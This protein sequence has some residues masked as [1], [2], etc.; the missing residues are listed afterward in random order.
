[1]WICSSARWILTRLEINVSLLHV[2]EPK[3]SILAIVIRSA[4]YSKKAEST[5]VKKNIRVN[6]THSTLEPVKANRVSNDVNNDLSLTNVNG[7]IE[8]WKRRL[9]HKCS[10]LS[11][12][13]ESYWVRFNGHGQRRLQSHQLTTSICPFP[14]LVISATNIEYCLQVSCGTHTSTGL[15]PNIWIIRG[16]YLRCDTQRNLIYVC[17]SI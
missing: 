10:N 17:L 1:M 13:R 8:L 11:S 6:A 5:T 9:W 2:A 15:Q 4:I 14:P 3:F 12:S 16:L 7:H